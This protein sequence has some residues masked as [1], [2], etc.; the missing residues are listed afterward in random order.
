MPPELLLAEH[1]RRSD[2]E[3]EARNYRLCHLTEQDRWFL[4]IPRK[5]RRLRVY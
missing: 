5:L 1:L 3:K 4:R 2:L